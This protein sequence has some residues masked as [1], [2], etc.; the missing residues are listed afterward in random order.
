MTLL[1]AGLDVSG[2][3]LNL[4]D[5]FSLQPLPASQVASFTAPNLGTSAP[6]ESKAMLWIALASLAVGIIALR[7]K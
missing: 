6:K 7:K 1:T 4:F 2:G 5:P 3:S